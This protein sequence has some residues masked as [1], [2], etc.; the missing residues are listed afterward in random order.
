[1]LTVTLTGPVPAVRLRLVRTVVCDR[2]ADA[3]AFGLR[4]EP[5][6]AFGRAFV[7]VP[8]EAGTALDGLKRIATPDRDAEVFAFVLGALAV[9]LDLECDPC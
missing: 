6:L 1:L 8:A 9:A 3:F 2:A 4:A 5:L 7:F